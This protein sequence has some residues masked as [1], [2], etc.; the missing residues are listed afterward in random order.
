MT[1]IEALLFSFPSPGKVVPLAQR[2]E[3]DGWDGLVLADSQNLQCDVYVELALA[4]SVT[5]RLRLGTS[6]T[7][8]VTR[9][10]AVTASA[11]ATLQLETGGRAL[12]GIGRGDSSLTFI[13]QTPAPVD[14]LERYTDQ[15]Q[16]YLR[17]EVVQIDGYAST[18][19]WLQG[20]AQPKVPVDVAATGPRT[21][22]AA[23]RVADRVTFTLPAQ[24]KALRW[25]I[26][27]ARSARAAAGLDPSHVSLGAY[28]VAAVDSDAA[29]AR[30]LVRANVGILA[31]FATR[32]IPDEA[33]DVADRDVL[34][35]LRAGYDHARHGLRTASHS[36][37][38]TD[39]FVDRFAVVGPADDCVERLRELIS[40]GLSHLV[41]VGPS[42][43]VDASAAAGAT[44]AL[45]VEVLP[46][47]RQA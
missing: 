15:L 36:D 17:G 30:D 27:T 6:V 46:A 12:L 43:D 13:G 3:N 32:A 28:V 2:T 33:L 25:A 35:R 14:A 8:P 23:A 45:A 4:G 21:I 44:R 42:R 11:I 41:V 1:G 47:L 24:K 31:R 39:D 38:L 20:S 10:P 34:A 29:A 9:H 37:V 40:L 5:E 18:I 26:D 19:E 7:N 22:E 16:R